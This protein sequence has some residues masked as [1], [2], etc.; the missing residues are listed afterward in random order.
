MCYDD[1]PKRTIEEKIARAIEAYEARFAQAPTLVWVSV[2]VPPDVQ[3]DRVVVERRPTVRPHNIWVG[4]QPASA[5]PSE[6]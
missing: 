3:I 5:G 1:S 2:T 6:A 4:Q